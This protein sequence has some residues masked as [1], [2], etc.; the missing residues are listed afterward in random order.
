MNTNNGLPSGWT[1]MQQP[2]WKPYALQSLI[3]TNPYPTAL[4]KLQKQKPT[5]FPVTLSA[6]SRRSASSGFSAIFFSHSDINQQLIIIP[7]LSHFESFQV[8]Y[9]GGDR[10]RWTPSAVHSQSAQQGR[11]TCPAYRKEEL[12][13]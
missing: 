12:A 7:V 6:R 9:L 13:D 3:D 11:D 10:Q 1:V 4:A 2:K 5:S 8:W